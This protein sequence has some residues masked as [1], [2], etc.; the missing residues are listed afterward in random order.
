MMGDEDKMPV[1]VIKGRD[2]LVPRVIEA[3][4]L[5]LYLF[6]NRHLKFIKS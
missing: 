3:Y 5:I 2:W 1:F 6:L 4:V